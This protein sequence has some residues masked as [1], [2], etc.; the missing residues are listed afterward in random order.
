MQLAIK[1]FEQTYQSGEQALAPAINIKSWI[2]RELSSEE[3]KGKIVLLNF[4]NIRCR[5]CIQSLPD[6][7]KLYDTYKDRGLVVITCA[8]GNHR[9][10]KDFLD[11]QGYSFPAGMVSYQMTLDYAIR[12]NPSYFMINRNGYL[13]WGPEHR[14]PTDDELES[15]LTIK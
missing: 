1:K 2:S 14:L 5:P 3:L 6:L 13:V 11:K 10:T 9:E 12:G 4:W 15:L 7:Q 8:G